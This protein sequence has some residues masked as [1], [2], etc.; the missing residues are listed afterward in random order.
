MRLIQGYVDEISAAAVTGWVRNA[1]APAERIG[2]DVV[3][4]G[5]VVGR[6]IGA[7]FY[8]PLADF[9]D[10]CYGFR[11]ALPADLSARERAAVQIIAEAGVVLE[12]AAPFQGYVDQRSVS[13]VAGWVRDRFDP[14]ARV[15]FEAVLPDGAVVARGVADRFYMAL[16][17]QGIGDAFYGFMAMFDM[18]LTEEQRDTVEVR[19]VGAA[20]LALSP[21]L[22]TRFELV[23]YMAMDIVNNCNLRCPFCLFDYS[24]TKSTR[25]MSQATFDSAMR[26]LPLVGDGGF[27]LSCL[28]EPSLHPDFQKFV[29]KIPRQWG[30][31]IMFTTNL[32]KRMPDSY[33]QAL[34]DAGLFHLNVSIESLQ[35]AIYEKFRKGARW[36]IFK[37]NWDR[38]MAAWKAHPSPTRIRYICMA[39]KSN[40]REIPELVRYLRAERC[41]WQVEIRYTFDLPHIPQNFRVNEYL[42]AADWAWLADQLRDYP[43]EEV[44]L[45]APWDAPQP[46]AAE[47]AAEMPAAAPVVE[48]AD[49]PV[50]YPTLPLNLHCRW[51]GRFMVCDKWDHPSEQRQIGAAS[52]T[53]L[54]DVFG[55]LMNVATAPLP[56]LVQGFVDEISTTAVAGWMRDLIHP[57]VRMPFKVTVAGPAGTRVIAE[58]RADQFY[59]ALHDFGYADA[60]YG[61]RVQFAAEIT[62]EERDSLEVV[63]ADES[64]GPLKRAPR[65]QGYVD[66]RSTR[67]VA[68]WIR[69]RFDP[70]ARVAFEVV[71]TGPGRER[72]LAEGVASDLVPDLVRDGVGDARYGFVVQFEAELSEAERDA[73]IVRPALGTTP[74]AVSP[75]LVTAVRET[76]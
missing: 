57:N 14:A 71:L 44:V 66:E 32:A 70:A 24:D 2:F 45:T 19:P 10:G 59:Q 75:R 12:R 39:Y 25:F 38:M 55:Y 42:D 68:G 53:E 22:D 43:I 27:W 16:A 58:G 9:G 4:D 13:H 17:Q 1:H 74:L 7:E 20:P 52:I 69:N 31:K 49:E 34:A 51:D 23:S 33:F 63:P 6:G 47:P 29:E 21:N 28:H 50:T 3:V 54:D 36:P 61:F 64:G 8:A 11:V 40:L 56:G 15:P 48:L 46:L 73:V 41:A 37:E 72:I 67:H 26:L 65:Y 5:R 35:P 62:A 30:R 76:A 60:R 18:P